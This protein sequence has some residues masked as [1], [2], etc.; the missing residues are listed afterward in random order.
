MSSPEEIGA[1]PSGTVLQERYR[2][3]DVLGTGA[4][5][6][7]YRA[8][9][10]G[11]DRTVAVKELYPEAY[12]LARSGAKVAVPSAKRSEHED[13]VTRVLKQ[14][15]LLRTLDH[16]HLMSVYGALQ[17]HN[18]AY[19]VVEYLEGSSLRKRLDEK[20]TLPDTEVQQ[21]ID[22]V[23]AGLSCLHDRDALHLDLKPAN[24]VRSSGRYVVIDYGAGRMGRADDSIRLSTGGFTPE[25][26]AIEQ[27]DDTLEKG[28]YTDIYA[29]GVTAYECLTGERPP[30]SPARLRAD[31]LT[32]PTDVDSAL[33]TALRWALEVSPE[34]RQVSVD[35][36]LSEPP[37]EVIPTAG[38]G[39]PGEGKDHP[40]PGE[41]REGHGQF[42]EWLPLSRLAIAVVPV[43][44]LG[45]L[46]VG[47]EWGGVIDWGQRIY[48]EPDDSSPTV[49][50]DTSRTMASVTGEDSV[51]Q[52][53]QPEPRRQGGNGGAGDESPPAAASNDQKGSEAQGEK[54]EATTN[55]DRAREEGSPSA[56]MLTSRGDSLKAEG[57]L[58]AALK[59]YTRA[60]KIDSSLAEA[61]KGRGDVLKEQDRLEP[62][63]ESYERAVVEDPFHAEAWFRRGVVLKEQDRLEAAIESYDRAIEEDSSFVA[64]AWYNRGIIMEEQGRWEEALE[65]YNLAIEEA[66]S[67]A[68]WYSRAWNNR[69]N[70]LQEQGRLEAALES[71][72]RAI[73]EDSSYA[74]AWN[75]RA[76]VL[77][78]QGR[79]EEAIKSFDQAI[80]EDPSYALAWANRGIIL[81]RRG[82]ESAAVESYDRAC[83]LDSEYCGSYPWS[84]GSEKG[85]TTPAIIGTVVDE[86]GEPMP[87]VNI[88]AIHQS[89]DSSYGTAA[90][91]DGKYFLTDLREGGPYTLHV[92][93]VGYKSIERT[94]IM[95]GGDEKKTIDL[96]MQM[97]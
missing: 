49:E 27:V 41:G 66:S 81:H 77:E 52:A 32:W 34:D 76:A 8:R 57:R 31:T 47:L 12:R 16:P 25:Y 59:T 38:E 74:V 96:K 22:E 51:R 94:G 3:D 78:K 7:T 93:F 23:G 42:R 97:K 1:L 69:G 26:A 71:Y 85:V 70:V 83:E 86:T 14:G 63:I 75:G 36:W 79:L 46:F 9:D 45:V 95:L 40:E 33:Q 90:H 84:E 19:L 56:Q 21:L 30:T 6:I 48:E 11:L 62:A 60:V 17:V 39:R 24:I 61:W 20:G 50:E 28:P 43:L 91:P 10:V 44:V 15:R 13:L 5:G 29:L 67:H 55:D 53:V 35:T 89:T 65:R 37:T 54:S 82:N 58:P 68:A 64:A 2:I 92:S 18:T 72:D 88:I 4:F 80:E 73:E 87:G